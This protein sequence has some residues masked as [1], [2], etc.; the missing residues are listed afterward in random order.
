[1]A[2]ASVDVGGRVEALLAALTEQG[3]PHVGSTGEELVRVLVE[4]YGA[5]LERIVEV[6]AADRP[7]LLLTLAE[8]PLVETQLILHGLHPIGPD[9][10]IERALDQVRPYLGSHAG[11]V[12]YLGIDD[13]GIAHL[14]LGGSCHGCP[15]STVTVRMTIEEAV[16]GAAPEVAGIEVEGQTE[17]PK[18]LLQIGLRPGLASASA[19]GSP[20]ADGSPVWL[21]PSAR[22][23]PAPGH[24]AQVHL[25][26]RPVLLCRIADTYYAYADCCP[27]CG[28]SLAGSTLIGDVLSCGSCR[29]AYDVRLAGRAMDRTGRHLDPLPLLDDVSGIR[30]ALVPE[31]V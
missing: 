4:F 11:G 27:T 7:D 26:G 18:P 15:S 12:D 31:A 25:D 1:M 6:V 3:G 30:V 5:G 2:G 28:G 10:R 21:H 17:E 16:L 19:A 14:R 13:D 29:A 8:D 22:D 23:L 20:A 24:A 9:E